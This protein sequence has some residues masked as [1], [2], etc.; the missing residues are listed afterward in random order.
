MRG[1]RLIGQL[2]RHEVAF[3][4][5]ATFTDP[6]L[7]E[8]VAIAGFDWV[9][10]VFEHAPYSIATIVE[11]QRAA[12]VRDLTTLVHVTGPADPAILQ[13]LNAGV[14]GIVCP[15]VRT[16]G[17]VDRLIANTKYPPLGDR[18][19]HGAMRSADYHAEDYHSYTQDA[20]ATTLTGIIVEDKPGGK[21]TWRRK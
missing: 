15:R 5:S 12:D 18:G 8:I 13:L 16:R 9:S 14:G 10:I 17:E 6:A 4:T 21:A 20:N 7:V 1:R 19:S 3:G 11:L 2:Q